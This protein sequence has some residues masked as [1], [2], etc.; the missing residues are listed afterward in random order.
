MTKKVKGIV[1]GIILLIF[2]V[3]GVSAKP[4]HPPLDSAINWGIHSSLGVVFMF[5]TDR[6]NLYFAH[7]VISSYAVPACRGVKEGIEGNWQITETTNSHVPMRHIITR[8][9]TAWRYEGEDWQPI[10]PQSFLDLPQSKG[11]K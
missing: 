5:K 9:A 4:E 1:L 8:E 2:Q 11:V 6:G 10:L 7:P 3:P